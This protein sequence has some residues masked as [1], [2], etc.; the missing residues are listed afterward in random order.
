VNICTDIQVA[1]GETYAKTIRAEGFKYS[2][3]NLWVIS[4]Q[5]AKEVVMQKM[6]AFALI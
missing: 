6:K 3:E 1:M 5:A 4:E 2:C